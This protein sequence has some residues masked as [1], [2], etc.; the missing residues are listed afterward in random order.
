MTK[1]YKFILC[2]IGVFFLFI[3]TGCQTSEGKTPQDNQSSSETV[4]SD[5]QTET[6]SETGIPGLQIA[7]DTQTKSEEDSESDPEAED[8]YAVPDNGAYTVEY[9]I[10]MI[11]PDFTYTMTEIE[12][13]DGENYSRISSGDVPLNGYSD[14]T[15]I[16][17][18]NKKYILDNE[19]KTYREIN[20]PEDFNIKDDVSFLL[21]RLDLSEHEFSGEEEFD[22]IV[23]DYVEFRREETFTRLYY[24]NRGMLVG[25]RSE[26]YWQEWEDHTEKIPVT[27]I[28]HITNTRPVSENDF[29]I[30]GDYK[31]EN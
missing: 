29:E 19:N 14:I 20:V 27:W 6:V 8:N 22:G 11:W 25:C 12:A 3:L 30:P 23:C 18:D 26:G 5:M 4:T 24:N 21:P 10:E 9:T 1:L 15:E 2:I 13:F 28:Y 7:P 17:K 31:Q 16:I